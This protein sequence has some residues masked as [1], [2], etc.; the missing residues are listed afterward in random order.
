[1]I[2]KQSA[3]ITRQSK[4]NFASSFKFL[5]PIKREAI[6]CVYAWCRKTDDIVDSFQPVAEKEMALE[7]WQNE[8]EA[9]FNGNPQSPLTKELARTLKEFPIEKRHFSD[10]I[11]AMWLDI[12]GD[13]FES[14]EKLIHYCY[15][16]AGTVG[17][18]AIEIFGYENKQTKL[19]AS[20]LGI[21][22]QLT[23]IIRDVKRDAKISRIYI[24]LDLMNIYGVTEEDI[25]SNRYSEKYRMMMEDFSQ[26]TLQYYKNAKAHLPPEDLKTMRPSLI[27][28]EIYY[29]LFGKLQKY[30][31]DVFNRNISLPS[32][33]KVYSA[34][35]G[36]FFP[37]KTLC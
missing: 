10:M 29:R 18:M 9:T 13:R 1:M 23:N 6:Y 36:W 37:G 31:F 35:K 33:E 30:H 5:P 24:P 32:V 20:D 2:K 12:K 8:L 15:G 34:L 19:F 21:A 27:M 16:V 3:K 28:G 17:L 25:V 26:R 22:L 4:S 7:Q 11:N 14:W